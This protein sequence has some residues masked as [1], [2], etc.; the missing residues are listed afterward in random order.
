MVEEAVV[1]TK[2]VFF[3]RSTVWLELLEVTWSVKWESRESSIALCFEEAFFQMLIYI[4]KN[5]I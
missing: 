2:K 5:V 1:Q 4:H 3:L